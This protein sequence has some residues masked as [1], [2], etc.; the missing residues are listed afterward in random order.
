MGSAPKLRADGDPEW[1][2]EVHAFALRAIRET[3][4]ACVQ[5]TL[6]QGLGRWPCVRLNTTATHRPEF[7]SLCAI[8][9]TLEA[10]CQAFMIQEQP[11]NRDA[12]ARK[13]SRYCKLG[14]IIYKM[15]SQKCQARD[16]L[17]RAIDNQ[18]ALGSR[19]TALLVSCKAIFSVHL[20][21]I[22][23]PKFSNVHTVVSTANKTPFGPLRDVYLRSWMAPW[24]FRSLN[25]R[26]CLPTLARCRLLVAERRKI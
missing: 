1:F 4:V 16:G 15:L 20:L 8:L 6:F 2:A 17:W 24:T 13:Q 3:G 11:R 22:T 23:A 7:L 19:S 10:F 12:L 18:R 14:H 21:P 9:E 5:N 25:E 26:E